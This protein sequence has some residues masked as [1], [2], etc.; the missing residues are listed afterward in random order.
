MAKRYVAFDLGAES[1]RSILATLDAQ[2]LALSETHRFANPHGRMNGHDHWDLLAQWEQIKTGLKKSLEISRE[3]AGI[4]IDTWGVDF[5][6]L[7]SDGNVLGNPFMYR[8]SRLNGMMDQVFSILPREEIFKST[9]IQ[10]MQINSLYQLFAMRSSPL[11]KIADKMLFV[12]DLFNYLFTGR[13]VAEYSIASTS[14]MLDARSGKWATGMLEKLGLPTGLLPE[15]VPSGSVLG[16][17]QKDVAEHLNCGEIPVIAPATH[18]TGSAVVAVPAGSDSWCYISSGT[19]SLMGVELSSPIVNETSAALNYTNEGGYGGTIR[20]LK[21]IMGL[22][23]VQECRRDLLSRGNDY[24]YAELTKMAGEAKPFAAIINPDHEPFLSAGQMPAKIA[25]FCRST[26]QNA[27]ESVGALIRACLEGLALTYRKTLE[28]L[29]KVLGR[30]IDTIHI[31]GG[32]TQNELLNQMTA[33]AC[34]RRVVAGPIEA[35]AIGNVLVQALALGDVKSLA[36]ARAIVRNSFPMKY[37]EPR[38]SAIW[39]AAYARYRDI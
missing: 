16:P 12:P 1:G 32:G 24:S 37:Y 23:L 30:R 19:W 38:D 18:D 3:I 11:L 5:G 15:I 4:G 25:E 36:E 33:D 13:K 26:N 6:L 2:K 20:F 21:N 31:L 10:F 35:T 8:D 34:Q 22:W 17:V 27:P 7:D 9:G 28:G 39:Q 14:Q 29:E